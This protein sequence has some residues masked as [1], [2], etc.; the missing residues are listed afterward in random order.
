MSLLPW[1]TNDLHR[2]S[3]AMSRAYPQL[4]WWQVGFKAWETM[5]AAPTVIAQR[6]ARLMSAGPI[7]GASDRREFVNMGTE[8]VVAF[9]QACLG[10]S[11]EMVSF[12]QGLARIACRQWWALFT[13]L[14]PLLAGRGT[15]P[16][17]GTSKI[18][19]SMLDAGNHSM[20]ALPRVAHSAVKPVHAKATSNAR[21]L[22]R[23]S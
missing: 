22:R 13:A 4:L 12:Q 5:F 11:R 23:P 9:S 14:N 21:R 19:M 7:P 20:S 15:Q 8:K 10:A 16:F 2:Y 3:R 6:T 18:V 17:S 1:N